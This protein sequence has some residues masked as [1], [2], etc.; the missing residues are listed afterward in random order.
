[1][2]GVGSVHEDEGTQVSESRLR[3]ER[4]KRMLECG[5]GVERGDGEDPRASVE[6][7]AVEFANR[8]NGLALSLTKLKA[9]RDRQDLVF[10]VLAGIGSS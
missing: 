3:M 10:K 1:M 4:A 2:A 6:G 9:F 7:R 5:V 8:V